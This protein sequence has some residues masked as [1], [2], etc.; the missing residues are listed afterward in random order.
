M[1][2]QLKGLLPRSDYLPRFVRNRSEQFESRIVMVRITEND[3]PWLSDMQGSVIPVA[4]AH[5]EGRPEFELRDHSQALFKGKHVAMQYVDSHH[6][7]TER[8][9]YNPNGAAQ[10]LAG[11]LAN[12]GRVLMMMPHPERVFRACQ[13]V[14]QDQEWK[15]DGPWLRLF[16]NARKYLN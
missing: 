8:Y 16:R 13:N 12:D 14:Y 11:V 15:E 10:G 1:I 9:P 2:S 7:I 3:S 4:V 5:G 6:Q